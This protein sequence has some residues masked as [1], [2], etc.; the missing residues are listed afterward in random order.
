MK[1]IDCCEA[2]PR[3][4]RPIAGLLQFI[5][6]LLCCPLAASCPQGSR[7][8][9][10]LHDG[11]LPN[12]LLITIDTLRADHVGCYSQRF[13]QL[14]P[15][16]DRFAAGATMFV[17]ATTPAPATLPALASL[18]TGLYP[19]RHPL[20]VNAGKLGNDVPVLAEMLRSHGYATAA[21][22]GNALLGPESGLARG[23]DTYE[24]FVAYLG[25]S[26]DVHG[27]DLV[28]AWIG[29]ARRSPWFLWVHFMDPHGPY[30]S[31]PISWSDKLDTADPLP[32]RELMVSPTNYG[33]DVIPKY[34]ELPG[35]TRASEYR[36]RY[37]G[38]IRFCDEQVG[39][40]LSAL[41]AA[42]L[43]RTT[44]VIITADH[45][46]DL[47]EHECYFQHGWV[48]YEDAVHVPLLVRL[49]ERGP[50]AQQ[51]QDPVSLVDLVPTLL[52]GLDLPARGALEGRDV[53]ALLRGRAL[54][55]APVF[56]VTAY[57]NQMT[58]VRHGNWKLVHTPP[59]PAS[60]QGDPWAGF[61]ALGERFELYDLEQD[62][63]ET[64][65]L[66][67]AQR[68]RADR[69]WAELAPWQAAHQIP[70]G[71]RS[72]PPLDEATRQRLE[73]LGYGAP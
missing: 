65:N 29:Q 63:G 18:H 66:Y 20:R 30:N 19:G 48:P 69:L 51:V 11:R 10:R 42:A 58:I 72:A 31:A 37:R 70:A 16:L 24:S 25:G 60:V 6:V 8:G 40:V 61:Y 3:P 45:G 43:E 44:L 14:T 57:L 67:Q 1:A 54:P 49:P 50:D 23:F 47:G 15:N 21:Y 2:H 56:A 39:R 26:A 5:A 59:P 9:L 68:A 34:Q 12:I 33:L 71:Q 41:E 53:S 36:R 46:E 17:H 13:G 55:A 52:A 27:A 35:L 64:H 73:A 7:G 22:F 4:R 28:R 38:E 32:D 62:P